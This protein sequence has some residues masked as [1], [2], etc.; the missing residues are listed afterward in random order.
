MIRPG[1]GCA[2]KVSLKDAPYILLFVVLATCF[3]FPALF[4]GKTALHNDSVKHALAILDY[5][6]KVFEGSYSLL[7]TNL[8][9]GGHPIMAE[10]QGGFF[11]PLTAF[12]VYYFDSIIGHHIYHWFCKILLAVGTYYL[13]RFYG[14]S[15]TASA[16]AVVALSWSTMMISF[17]NN[18]TLGSTIVWVPW[19]ILSMA[20]LIERPN[21]SRA[22]PLGIFVAL[23]ILSGYPQFFH[24]LVLYFICMLLPSAYQAFRAGVANE[25][26]TKI[27]AAGLFGAF[28]GA[29]LSAVQWLPL[30]ELTNYSH[31]AEGTALFSLPMEPMLRSLL[32]VNMS[33]GLDRPTFYGAGSILF[34]VVVST[35]LLTKVSPRMWGHIFGVVFLFFLALGEAT[36]T[37]SV[38]LN[39][40]IIPG[41]DKFR[42]SYPYMGVA[43]LGM[44][45]LSASAI[46]GL[47]E[48]LEP[49]HDFRRQHSAWTTLR[50]VLLLLFWL[51]AVYFFYHPSVPIL[52]I[53]L[54]LVAVCLVAISAWFKQAKTIPWFLLTV[55]LAETVVLKLTVFNFYPDTDLAM[56]ASVKY[57]QS[58]EDIDDFKVLDASGAVGYIFRAP[59]DPAVR[60]DAARMSASMTV[61]SNLRWGIASTQGGLAL[62]Q[63]RQVILEE[64]LLEEIR[65]E[66][67]QAPGLRL[68]D[69]LG[70]RYVVVDDWVD[71]P[72]FKA[73]YED[74]QLNVKIMENEGAQPRFQFYANYH[75]ANTPLEARDYLLASENRVLVIESKDM[76]EPAAT[77]ENLNPADVIVTPV[78]VSS[79]EYQVMLESPIDGWFYLSDANYPG[80]T[81]SIDGL[82]TEVY[83]AQVLGK[84]IRVPAGKHRIVFRFTSTAFNIGLWVSLAMAIVLLGSGLVRIVRTRRP[85]V[86]G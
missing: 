2:L 13:C 85:P 12:F 76:P 66:R 79:D 34:C 24:G 44:A 18:I 20:A 8:I 22:V 6:R 42:L 69:I 7:W 21:V 36:S 31:R 70:I 73:I 45:V 51:A 39:L 33:P 35:I 40:G 28:I 82:S 71:S 30:L 54:A 67:G 4:E 52:Q 29:A 65:G 27:L 77:K 19:A 56:P 14:A 9:Y 84:A 60:N 63:Q 62:P 80:W 49:R 5:Y 86:A 11:N 74:E 59:N 53:Y 47:V 55:L 78:L 57:L 3:Y 81:A 37:F 38:L 26:G 16:F 48:L 72:G 1:S 23:T 32:F 83:S 17:Q 46:D 41:L 10:G 43:L 58:V 15:R 61:N 50:L 25:W 64:K 68:I 75:V